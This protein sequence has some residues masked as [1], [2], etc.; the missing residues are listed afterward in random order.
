MGD[1]REPIVGAAEEISVPPSWLSIGPE[2]WARAEEATQKI[3]GLVQP[4]AG[5]EERRRR[6]MD[7]VRRLIKGR[8]GCEVRL[9]MIPI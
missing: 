6:V 2:R 5:S 7:Y 1:L 4:S 3:V 9:L 8:L